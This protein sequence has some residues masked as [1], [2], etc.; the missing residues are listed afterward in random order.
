MKSLMVPT[1]AKLLASIADLGNKGEQMA[2]EYGYADAVAKHL[3]STSPEVMTATAVALGKMGMAGAKYS[4]TIAAGLESDSSQLKIAAATALGGFGDAAAKHAEK[5]V[6]V[7]S[8]STE[9]A[10]KIAAIQALGQIGADSKADFVAEMLGDRSPDIQ[11]AACMALGGML[12][13]GAAKADEI[14]KKLTSEGTQCA[15]CCALS[16]LGEE[17]VKPHI[18]AIV[19][20]CVASK[21]MITRQEALSALGKTGEDAI[22]ASSQIVSLLTHQNPAVRA[23]A[24]L[25]LGNIGEKAAGE[26]GA[27]VK[28]L[29]DEQ[30][31][32]AWIPLQV[33]GGACREPMAM[34]KPKCA[35]LVALGGMKSE[36]HVSQIEGYLQ[37][38]D[39]EV[40]FCA[41]EALGVIGEAASSTA[42]K[43]AS[44]LDDDTY[45]VRAKAC[46]ALGAMKAGDQADKIID[47]F[48]DK[49]QVVRSEAVAAVGMMG[50]AGH[51]FTGEIAKLLSDL[52][53]NVRAAAV[54]ALANLGE[55]GQPYASVIANLLSDPDYN[56]VT[57]VC[58]SLGKMG[59]YG[60]AFAEDVA[61]ML[62]APYSPLKS[63]AALA[64]GK[65]G[66]EAKDFTGSLRALTA[67]GDPEVSQAANFALETLAELALDDGDVE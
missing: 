13:S 24:A 46:Y 44:L 15:A 37:D 32:D 14:A 21:D 41:V 9:E 2:M 58:A 42:D 23:A 52:S 31:D 35:A 40:R 4:D 3:S 38:S 11:S 30:E 48:K 66:A 53:P 47:M 60:A 5:L 51:Q 63:A 27:I 16:A 28:L 1:E 50:E 65:M 33:G 39:W 34:R 12:Y 67:D 25:A 43:V 57:E 59:A 19:T 45:P 18:A 55:G 64:L 20:N 10:V 54:G 26:A 22:D 36:T 62:Q 17:A 56:V 61:L 49:T 7:I 8:D 6:V 29:A